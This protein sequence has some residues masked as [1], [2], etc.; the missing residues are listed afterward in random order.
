MTDLTDL[1]NVSGD[2]LTE[3]QIRGILRQIDLD[4]T[5]LVR[6]GKLSALTYATGGPAGRSADRAGN[7]RALLD[8]RTHYQSLLENRT[9]WTVS[10]FEA[11]RSM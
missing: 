11:W 7:L 4:I 2:P 6:D 9:S 1:N 8:A 5:N 10:Q 3:E